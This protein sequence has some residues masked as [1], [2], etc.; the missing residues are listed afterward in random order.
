MITFR[1]WTFREE[2]LN[3][4]GPWSEC[5]EVLGGIFHGLWLGTF[6]PWRRPYNTFLY[7]PER[8]NLK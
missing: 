8:R 5:K 3:I 6:E 7:Y 1:R 4:F 2:L